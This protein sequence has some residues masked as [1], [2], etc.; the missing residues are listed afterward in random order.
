MPQHIT[1][2][3]SSRIYSV[4][5][6]TLEP[7]L[8]DILKCEKNNPEDHVGLNNNLQLVQKIHPFLYKFYRPNGLWMDNNGF[9][10]SSFVWTEIGEWV[11]ASDEIGEMVNDEFW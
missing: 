4:D 3:V 5:T 7:P 11:E 10:I 1:F 2:E 9:K 6:G 8:P